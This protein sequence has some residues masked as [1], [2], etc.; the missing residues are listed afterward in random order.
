MVQPRL[1]NTREIKV[2][3]ML[4]ML[5]SDVCKCY[6]LL[7]NVHANT[8]ADQCASSRF[9][10]QI[11]KKIQQ[12]EQIQRLLE[13]RKCYLCSNEFDFTI[14]LENAI[15][16]PCQHTICQSCVIKILDEN[17]DIFSCPMCSQLRIKSMI[18][19]DGAAY[20]FPIASHLAQLIQFG[21]QLDLTM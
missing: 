21:Q 17:H 18:Y 4:P 10:Y 13:M 1:R 12:K 8:S 5:I 16:P 9:Q 6:C 15:C 7:I 14:I 11:R 2:D 3:V 19:S 20:S